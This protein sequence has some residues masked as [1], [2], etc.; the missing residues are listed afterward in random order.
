MCPDEHKLDNGK[1]IKC[2]YDQALIHF[3]LI[4]DKSS[5]GAYEEL[6]SASSQIMSKLDV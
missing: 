4:G 3:A 1:V 6:I 2:V 5:K